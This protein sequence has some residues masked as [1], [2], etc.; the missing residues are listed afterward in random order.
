MAGFHERPE[1]NELLELRPLLVA[2]SVNRRHVFRGENYK[3]FL[4]VQ[5]QVS[6]HADGQYRPLSWA[7]G[8]L[9]NEIRESLL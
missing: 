1:L 7:R 6:R 2:N 9:I 3:S 8:K 4:A 5:R